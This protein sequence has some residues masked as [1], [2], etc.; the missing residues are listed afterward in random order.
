MESSNGACNKEIPNFPS[1]SLCLSSLA[2]TL[3]EAVDDY[4]TNQT[5]R[6]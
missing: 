4:E 1:Y 6:P 3:P 2:Q 5:L